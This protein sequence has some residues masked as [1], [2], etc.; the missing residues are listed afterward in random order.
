MNT[1]YKYTALI[2]MQTHQEALFI[3]VLQSIHSTIAISNYMMYWYNSDTLFIVQL[4]YSG[5][6]LI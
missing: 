3:I 5:N 6:R 1:V 2:T 4:V